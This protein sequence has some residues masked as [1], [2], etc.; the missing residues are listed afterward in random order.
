MAPDSGV[1]FQNRGASFVLDPSHPNVIEP[2]KRPMHTIIPSLA[3]KQ[4]KP[5]L[6]FGVMGGH[7]QP[8][9]QAHVLSNIIDYGMDPQESLDFPRSF[10]FD[11]VL[12]CEKSIPEDV[13]KEL[14]QNRNF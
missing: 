10:Y 14:H 1:L 13:R 2:G 8:M 3:T 5:Y 7:Y 4:N 12:E 6:S 9:G 11:G